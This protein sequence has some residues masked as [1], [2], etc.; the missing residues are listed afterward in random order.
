[1]SQDVL[2]VAP[3]NSILILSRQEFVDPSRLVKNDLV[4][5]VE[6]LK[7]LSCKHID[8]HHDS[9]GYFLGLLWGED[10]LASVT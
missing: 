10:L 2:T 9:V 8:L 6:E 7:E 4:Q 5:V 3:L 1:M